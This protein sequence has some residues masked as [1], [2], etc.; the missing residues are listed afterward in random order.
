[1]HSLESGFRGIHPGPFSETAVVGNR[2]YL[3]KY[4]SGNN[5]STHQND[6][7][8][9]RVPACRASDQYHQP[10]EPKPHLTLI[11]AVAK[12]FHTFTINIQASLYAIGLSI[13]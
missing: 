7:S 9:D 1:M 2:A 11:P 10:I 6:P 3:I 4:T 12:T 5:V 8:A 13:K